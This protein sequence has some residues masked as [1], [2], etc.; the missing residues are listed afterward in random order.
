MTFVEETDG[1]VILAFVGKIKP[2]RDIYE[3]LLEKYDLNLKEC[4]FIDGR[5]IMLKRH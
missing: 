3:Y 1:M 4:V 5:L 2:N